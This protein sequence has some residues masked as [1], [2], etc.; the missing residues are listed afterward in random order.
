MKNKYVIGLD[1][2]TLS[3]QNP[4]RRDVIPVLP[5]IRRRSVRRRI[6][7]PNV[8]LRRVNHRLCP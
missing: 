4:D 1:Y 8:L 2:G 6:F 7:R 3:V 5:R